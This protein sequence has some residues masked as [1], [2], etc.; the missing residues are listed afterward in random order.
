MPKVSIIIPVYNTEKYL[1]KSL[2][3][4]CNQT[5]SNIEI[6]CINDCS[7]DKSMDILKEYFLKDERI[8]I[9]DFKEN[10]GAAAARNTGIDEANG[11]YIGFVDS[12]DFVDIDF[13]EKLYNAAIEENSDIAKGSYLYSKNNFV[14]DTIN[15][16]IETEKTNFAMEYCSAIFK[17]DFLEKNN[18]D[19]PS[20]VDLE[21][22][23]FAFTCAIKSNKIKILNNTYIH[24][25]SRENSQTAQPITF[26]RMKDRLAGINKIVDLA[27]STSISPESYSYVCATWFNNL[28]YNM[29]NLNYNERQYLRDESI[30][31]IKKIKH[32]ASFL[33]ELDK[34][35]KILHNI[36]ANDEYDSLLFL[37]KFKTI[38]EQN[39]KIQELNNSILALNNFKTSFIKKYITADTISSSVKDDVYFISVVNN[40]ELFNKCIKDNPFVK[41]LKNVKVVDYDNTK[42]NISITKRYN[43]FINNFDYTKEAWFIFCHCDWEILSNIN[44]KLP[45]LNKNYLYGNIGSKFEIFNGKYFKPLV[46][47]C[48]ECRRDGSGIYSSGL[49]YEE[50]EEVD[51]FDCQMLMV[52]SSLINKYHLLFD[53]N[54]SWDLYVEDF[55]IN[56]K[57][58][59]IPS[60]AINMECCHWSGWHTLPISYK[61]PLSYMN[62]KYPNDVYAGTCSNIGNKAFNYKL[63]TY[64][65]YMLYRMIK[66]VRRLN[67]SHA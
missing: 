1:R 5:L 44:E 39:G 15:N 26:N 23:V 52:H 38:N 50:Q 60:Y 63:A 58:I 41:N 43:H 12:D 61:K 59:G 32:K 17:K 7:T 2:D 53:E 21:D 29:D 34:I 40:Y 31:I 22:P 4:V 6:I 54:L 28:F 45:Q 14:S 51:T 30:S 67:N 66:N 3:S 25:S 48:L 47:H 24:I 19:F 57:K 10:K 13:Y 62:T 49:M 11:E 9:I 56:A 55:C 65:E 8:K 64:K 33:S 18:I 42:E 35:S 37:D 16:M 27:N 36:V 46:G 20:I